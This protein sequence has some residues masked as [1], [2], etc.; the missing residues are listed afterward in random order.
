MNFLNAAPATETQ[1]ETQ[2]VLYPTLQQLVRLLPYDHKRVVDY[3]REEAKHNPFLI[4]DATLAEKSETL[5][6][7]V[8]PDWYTLPAQYISLSEH[9]FG[10]ISALSI[11][12][13]QREALIYLTQWISSSGYLEETPAVWANGSIWSARELEAV[14]PVLQS[15]DPP[16]IA[17]RSGQECLL[18]QLKEKPQSLAFLLVHGYLKELANCTGASI[19]ASSNREI[20]L[21][22]LL[23]NQAFQNI[24]IKKIN[25][26]IR[27]IQELE[28]RPARNF[29]HDN[30]PIVTPDLKA[31]LTASGWQISLTSEVEQR[32]CLNSEAVELLQKSQLRTR[33]TQQL[34]ALYKRA[35]SL[36][37]ALHLWQEN[38]LKVGQFL[39]E[40]QQAF[41]QSRD[42]LDLVPTPQQL[43][44]QSV[45]LSNSTISRI[46]RGRYML[47]SNQY[48][49]IFPLHLLCVPARVGGRT[50][51]QIQQMLVQL[52]E[53]ESTANPYS[54]EQLSQ[55]LRVRFDLPITRRTVTKYRKIAAIESSHKRRRLDD[56]RGNAK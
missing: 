22:R 29:G 41:L 14:V 36:L 5:L 15:F 17:A 4:E 34:E 42:R 30:A 48:S 52:I 2:T 19:E 26:A 50:P 9:L 21:H 7:D 43:V 45:G 40:R 24:D 47:I 25:D 44:A 33:D 12:S 16:G 53:E 55:L 32:F 20:L 56:S 3:V 51:P 54:D 31:E 11:P 39:V 18:L 6:E 23:Q 38:L 27:E 8:L 49:K 37:T 35:K 10:Q 46:V 13:R 28:P 1:L